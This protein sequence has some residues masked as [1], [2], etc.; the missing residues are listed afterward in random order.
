MR[1]YCRGFLDCRDNSNEQREERIRSK[2]QREGKLHIRRG[3]GELITRDGETK[4][5]SQSAQAEEER[6][7]N[8]LPVEGVLKAHIS[9]VRA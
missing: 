3:V 1:N 9:A 6:R 7:S 8:A 2:Q 4:E 5:A